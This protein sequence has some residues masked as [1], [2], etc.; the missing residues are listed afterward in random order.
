MF[1]KVDGG[2]NLAVPELAGRDETM[3]RPFSHY[4]RSCI[5]DGVHGPLHRLGVNWIYGQ[6]GHRSLHYV[7][8]LA[9][10][11]ISQKWRL[12]DWSAPG[13]HVCIAHGLKVYRW[14]GE[15]PGLF[16]LLLSCDGT[17]VNTGTKG[18]VC[19]LFELVTESPVH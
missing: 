12:C 9:V 5:G 14:D 15:D 7:P 2:E 4:R 3:P 16:R 13:D 8:Q 10:T 1:L 11:Q 19:R 18:G 6:D 17:A